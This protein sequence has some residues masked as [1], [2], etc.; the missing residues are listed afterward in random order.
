[1]RVRAM[2]A[3]GVEVKRV[4][5]RAPNVNAFAERWVQSLRHECL[6]RFVVLGET[7]LRHLVSEYLAH[8]NAERPHQGK[9]N[10]W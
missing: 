9:G 4:G 7:H 8:Y 1:M 6:D 10:V 2:E 3:E 5:P